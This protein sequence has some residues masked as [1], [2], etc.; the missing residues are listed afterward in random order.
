MKKKKKS[1][2]LGPPQTFKKGL[3]RR[4]LHVLWSL[5]VRTRDH[6]QCQWCEYEDRKNVNK[7][8]HAHHIVARSL[9]G[10]SGAFDLKNGMTLCYHHHIDCIK[11]D[12]DSYIEFRNRWLKD[13]FMPDYH[14]LRQLYF[15]PMKFTEDF[16]NAQ[17]KILIQTL[18]S[19]GVKCV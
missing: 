2:L 5:T 11:A 19:Y 15:E 16:Y 8:H 13:N 6:F 1:K 17:R 12:P 10:T 14:T 3:A 7:C 4:K 18:E 9:T